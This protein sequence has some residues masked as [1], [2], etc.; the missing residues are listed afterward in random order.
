MSTEAM[1]AQSPVDVNVR[2]LEMARE[3]GFDT[4]LPAFRDGNA[5][6]LKLIEIARREERE[7]AMTV[8]LSE[9]PSDGSDAEI[10]LRR[11]W[12][13]VR[14]MRANVQDQGRAASCES[15]GSQG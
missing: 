15:P 11:A 2:A 1:P 13:R 3:A 5:I 6:A 9:C 14:V 10:I 12:D 8:I 4:D 7:L